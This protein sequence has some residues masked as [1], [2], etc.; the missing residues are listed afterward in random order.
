MLK[1]LSGYFIPNVTEVN[2][3]VLYKLNSLAPLIKS[4][5]QLEISNNKRFGRMSFTVRSL[6]ASTQFK[7]PNSYFVDNIIMQ[8][9]TNFSNS[10]GGMLSLAYYGIRG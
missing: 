5:G 6:E 10:V 2:S 9:E 4:G 7:L 8:I 3:I 1:N